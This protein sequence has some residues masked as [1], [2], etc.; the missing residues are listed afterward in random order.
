MA[1][2]TAPGFEEQMQRLQAITQ[3]LERADLPLEKSVALYKEGR[4]LVKSCRETLE[5]ARLE[6]SLCGD[7]GEERPFVPSVTD[8]GENGDG[9]R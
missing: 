6:I 8:E 4:A 1:K 7:D 3:E 9:D 5:K 2:K